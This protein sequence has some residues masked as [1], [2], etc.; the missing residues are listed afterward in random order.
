MLLSNRSQIIK[1]SQK[2]FDEINVDVEG[3]ETFRAVILDETSIISVNEHVTVSVKVLKVGEKVPVTTK[4]GKKLDKQECIIADASA[5]CRIVLWETTI[6]RLVVDKSYQVNNATV[7]AY[8]GQSYL[9]VSEATIITEIDD[10]DVV[11]LDEDNFASTEERNLEGE[12]VGVMFS[13]EYLSCLACKAKVQEAGGS[14]VGECSKCH[15]KVKLSKCPKS[16]IA[17]VMF[18]VNDG[19]FYKQLLLFGN[20]LERVIENVN[21]NDVTE[22]L[23]NVPKLKLSVSGDAVTS[24]VIL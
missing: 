6:G 12:I 17:R 19:G 13:D 24:V 3:S 5:N 11:E 14:A 4:N 1:S 23:L 20:E 8:Q 9:S 18:D 21:G 7:R 15:L 2:K 16:L 10:I 22:K